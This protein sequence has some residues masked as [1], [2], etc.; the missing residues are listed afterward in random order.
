MSDLENNYQTQA[1]VAE[2]QNKMNDILLLREKIAKIEIEINEHSI[3]TDALKKLPANRR[4][5][6][7]VAG[8]LVETDVADALHSTETQLQNL[9]STK[10]KY[11]KDCVSL[12]QELA[13]FQAEHN[14]RFEN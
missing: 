2:A 13:D 4:A 6:R 7:L 9:K 12:E 14:I 1:I 11:E 8:L 3:V 5:H 10:T